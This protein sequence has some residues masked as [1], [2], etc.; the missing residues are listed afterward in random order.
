MSN[1][2]AVDKKGLAKLMAGRP[3][4]FVLYE[5]LQNAWDQKVTKVNVMV[6][7]IKGVPMTEISVEDDDPDGFAD[8]AHAYTLFAE[9]DKKGDAEKRGRFNIGEKLVLALAYEGKIETRKGAVRFDREGRHEVRSRR[10][11]GS[12]ITV[13]LPMTRAEHQEVLDAASRVIVPA[14]IRT[15]IN[16]QVI[17]SRTPIVKF[18]VALPT[19]IASDDGVMKSTTRKTLVQVYKPA[20]GETAMLYEMGIPV[21]ETGDLYHVD[22]QQKVPLNMDRDNVTPAYLRT[23]RAAVLNETHHL[24]ATVYDAS[25]P[26]VR[27]ACSD[28]R[29]SDDAVKSVMN[30][31]FGAD[32]VTYDASDPEANKLSVSQGRPIVYGG[33]LSAAE[34]DNVRRAGALPAAGTVTPSAKPYSP[35]GKPLTLVPESDWSPAIHRFVD[36]AKVIGH[37]LLGTTVLV[38]IAR[39]PGWRYD[40][41]YGP[42]GNLVVNLMRVGHAFFEDQE[43]QFDFLIHEFGHQ[44][45]GDHLSEDYYRALTKLGAKMT[46]LALQNPEF[47]Q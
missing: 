28:G 37:E 17:P 26:W 39:E 7:P 27:E 31:R 41:T 4:A 16:G 32:A 22:V 34:W 29:V 46:M 36:R 23:L 9:S 47:F 45:C 30:M 15:T 25:Q 43:R 42:S 3:K 20:D 1:W 38:A 10:P 14:K 18:R 44:Y 11:A 24:L 21:V 40:G 6:T 2:F 19:L 8:L 13:S 35:D 12:C 5:L 33:T